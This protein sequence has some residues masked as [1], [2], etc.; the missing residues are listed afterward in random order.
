MSFLLMFPLSDCL[1]DKVSHSQ[2]TSYLAVC[3][4]SCFFI[5]LDLLQFSIFKSANAIPLHII[6]KN[7]PL[8]GVARDVV[9]ERTIKFQH[10]PILFSNLER[11]QKYFGEFSSFDRFLFFILF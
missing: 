7:L 11:R 4:K 2:K 10:L 5:S 6:A 9:N 1:Y 3:L 8:R